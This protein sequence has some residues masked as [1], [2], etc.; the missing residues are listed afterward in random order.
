VVPD[1]AACF[2]ALRGAAKL[3]VVPAA[4]LDEER[5]RSTGVCEAKSV[6]LRCRL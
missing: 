6:A 4:A 1:P 3:A 2:I 5:A